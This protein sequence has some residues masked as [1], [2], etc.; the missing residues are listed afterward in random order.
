MAQQLFRRAI[1]IAAMWVRM[2]SLYKRKIPK[3]DVETSALGMGTWAIGGPTKWNDGR[4]VGWGNTSDEESIRALDRAFELGMRV[5]DTADVYGCG[6][7]EELVGRALGDYR[8]EIIII[9]KFGNTFDQKTKRQLG[10]DASPKYIRKAVDASLKRLR[11]GYIDIYLLHAWGY[12]I[13]RAGETMDTLEDL[14][15]EGVIRGYGWSTDSTSRAGAYSDRQHYV[16]VMSELN[17]FRDTSE[18]I[19]LCEKKRLLDLNKAPLA[20]GL[21]SGM[22]TPQTPQLPENDVRTASP[23]WLVYFKNGKAVP[24]FTRK[25]DQ[26]K[27]ILTEDGR[28]LVQ[29]SL[30]WIWARSQVTLPVP[31]FKTVKQVEENAQALERGPLKPSQMK[32]IDEILG[33]RNLIFE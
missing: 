26:I 28:T 15:S 25:L 17:V 12:P 19:S 16:A 8:D 11:T 2:V 14:V 13:D 18:I 3:L 21:L 31:G 22:F 9:T 23:D 4:F 30:G 7:S 32:A 5:F 27:G 1:T 10:E 20:M 29:G 33:T 24:E 6:L